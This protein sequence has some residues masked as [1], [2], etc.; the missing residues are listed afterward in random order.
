MKFFINPAEL[1]EAL[2]IVS[3]A[4]S[5]KPATPILEGLLILA[6]GNRITLTAT[7]MDFFIETKVSADIKIEGEAVIKGKFLTDFVRKLSALSNI[8]IE[9]I[10][11]TL[12]VKYLGNEVEI[13]CLNEEVFPI[14]TNINDDISFII[15]ESDFKE[16]LETSLFCIA[17]DDTRPILKGCLIEAKDQTVTAVAL[18]GYRLAV[19]KAEIK[20]KK[21]EVKVVIP[22]K[23]MGEI[24]KILS[25]SE[26]DIKI[27]IQR[28][29]VLFNL[30]H[31]RI[32][33]RLLEGEYI[34]YEKILPNKC[35]TTVNISREKLLECLDRASLMVK[36]KKSNY[37]KLS[38][39]DN[40]IGINTNSEYGAIRENVACEIGGNNLEIAFNSKYLLEALSRIKN[41]YIKIEL[42][43][44]NAPAVVMPVDGEKFKFI[45]LPVRIM[46]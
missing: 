42:A 38:I 5:S 4:L 10:G 28:N 18:D 43:S 44:G 35:Y 23:I 2:N 1:S 11:E 15:K 34:Q 3:R 27:N 37:L 17:A 41:E 24:V 45:V 33:T 29:L 46:N 22:G 32:T 21:G 20:D 31:T 14:L 13:P 12:M 9:K 36:N 39:G 26:N 7:D 16:L 40:V 19:T 25:D 30:G 8:E 6:E